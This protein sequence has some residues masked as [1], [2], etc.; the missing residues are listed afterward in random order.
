MATTAATTMVAAVHHPRPCFR[1]R[2]AWDM[3]PSASPK[4]KAKPPPPPPPPLPT[5]P[6]PTHADLFARHSNSEGQVPK[7][8]TSMGFERWWLP[9]PPEVKKPRS[10]YNA[11]SLAYLGDCIYEL[12]ARR[13]FFFPPLSINDYNKRVMDVVKCESQ[14][15]LLNK[16]LGEDFLTQEERDILRWGRNIVSSKTRTR[17]RA[18]IAVYN[19][20]SSLETLIGYLYLTNFKRL[21]QLM[22]QLGFTSGASSH[23]IADELVSGFKKKNSTSVQSQQQAAQ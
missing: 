7:K 21:E 14:D 8:T 11:A 9:P 2:A 20:A 13:H 3:N 22:F 1:V 16:L 6:A 23:H 19:R 10:L 5:A 18:G 17:K 4:P 15:L 12:Y